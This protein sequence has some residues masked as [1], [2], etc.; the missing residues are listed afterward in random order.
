M[1]RQNKTLKSKKKGGVTI[2]NGV[3]CEIGHNSSQATK[4][5]IMEEESV[6]T[7][8]RYT[9]L[10][11]GDLQITIDKTSEEKNSFGEYIYNHNAAPLLLHEECMSSSRESIKS[12][13]DNAS[14][15]E[16]KSENLM[17]GNPCSLDEFD[18]KLLSLQDLKDKFLVTKERI[19]Q[20]L[21]RAD[22]SHKYVE[23]LI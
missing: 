10:L 11:I 1:R 16:N 20:V 6:A 14:T 21:T 9:K 8:E 7:S 19:V 13:K 4:D 2:C 3:M 22:A 17:C 15:I 12:D 18:L 5:D 23:D